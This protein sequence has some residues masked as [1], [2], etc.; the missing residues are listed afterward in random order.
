MFVITLENLVVARLLRYASI[1]LFSLTPKSMYLVNTLDSP[2]LPPQPQGFGPTVAFPAKI[3]AVAGK[4]YAV[5][6]DPS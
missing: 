5:E 6:L 1:G 4:V 2:P 3:S